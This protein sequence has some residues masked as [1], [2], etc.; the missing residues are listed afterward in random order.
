MSGHPDGNASLGINEPIRRSTG[1]RQA[2]GIGSRPTRFD[3]LQVVP[4]YDDQPTNLRDIGAYNEKMLASRPRFQGCDALNCIRSECARCQPED[5]FG[6]MHCDATMAQN[7]RGNE[8]MPVEIPTVLKFRLNHLNYGSARTGLVETPGL[9]T[10]QA[11][12]LTVLGF[13]GTATTSTALGWRSFE[14]CLTLL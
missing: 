11:L 4:G 13:F 1:S 12:D 6:C 9:Q 8:R 14:K 10:T 3:V 7:P 2:P 5:G